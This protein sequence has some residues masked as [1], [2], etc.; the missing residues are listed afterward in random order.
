[1]DSLEYFDHNPYSQNR[2]R[3]IFLALFLI[4]PAVLLFPFTIIIL[5]LWAVQALFGGRRWL[6]R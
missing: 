2:V 6:A 1:V 4:I 3:E 5:F